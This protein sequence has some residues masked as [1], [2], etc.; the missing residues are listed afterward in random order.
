MWQRFVLL[1]S[2]RAQQYKH[3]H[4]LTLAESTVSVIY[5]VA[6][7]L[8]LLPPLL[9][10]LT[11]PRTKTLMVFILLF[12]C[13]ISVKNLHTSL[14]LPQLACDEYMCFE[15]NELPFEDT[16]IHTNKTS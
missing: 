12:Q 16:N 10:L 7:W 15:L 9:L 1:A 14:V 5:V 11:S 13:S 8:R 3:S 4:V 6:G 2:Q